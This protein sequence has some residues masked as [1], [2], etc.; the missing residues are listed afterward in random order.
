MRARYQAYTL[1]DNA[2]GTAYPAPTEHVLDLS[3]LNGGLNLWELEYMLPLNQS[4]DLL[5]M[6]WKDGSISSRPGQDYV[7]RA[8]TE[9]DALAHNAEETAKAGASA[10]AGDDPVYVPQYVTADTYG[11]F[12]AGYERLWHD[13]WICQK[14]KK[15][16]AV[17]PEDGTHTSIYSGNLSEEYGGSF[18]V[19]RENLY[20]MNG[21]EYIKISMSGSTMTAADVTPYIPTVVLNRNPDGTG[22]DLYEDE[23]RISAGRKV[24]FTAD[25]ES[26]DYVLPYKNLDNTTMTAVVNGVEVAENSGF[27]VDRTNGIVTFSTAPTQ[28]QLP[29][30]NNVTITCYVTDTDA[31]NSIMNS[32]CAT[33]FG[34]G[35]AVVVVV[36]GTPKQPNAYFWSGNTAYGLDPSYFPYQS[37]NFAGVNNE[38][39][40][41]FGKQQSMLV[42]FKEHSIGKTYFNTDSLDDLTSIT[43]PYTP[44]NDV[45]GCS[46]EKSIKLIQNNLIFANKESG[47]YVLLDTSTAGENNVKRIS[48]NVEGSQDRHGLLYDMR[49]S[50]DYEVCAYDDGERYW[51]CA[52]GRVYLWD[53]EVSTFYTKE[54]KLSWF[55]FDGIA[56]INWLKTDEDDY[57]G[58]ADGSLIK[59]VPVFSDFGQG[60][61]RRYTFA[62]Q[63]FGTY[64]TLKD[65]L[66]V[67]FSAKSNTGCLINIKY[68][69]DYESRDDLTLIDLRLSKSLIPRD[70]TQGRF[71]RA[72][73]Y[74]GTAI[75]IPRC[76]HIRHFS[77]T[78]YN[79]VAETDMGVIGAQVV[80]R[81]SRRD[82]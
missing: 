1:K 5:N 6:Y 54:E 81:Y 50:H 18:F 12:Y 71:L 43:L 46:F 65:V 48:R 57:Y 75:R 51:L 29:V 56:P 42:I 19:L 82:R 32:K 40:T 63:H 23:N 79:D 72:I 22:G 73:R 7:Y 14:G 20:Y 80:Y 60:Y 34:T 38:Y 33:A 64:D 52:N 53:Y 59:F 17:N 77:M 58:R 36:G 25:G 74:A 39:I 76:F 26:V 66:R 28:S 16:Y 47:V 44:I 62:V 11:A 8:W 70:I 35:N 9:E 2:Y 41:G 61:M 30:V 67:I 24:S 31:V 21:H 37:Y 55:L 27:T 10:A 45:I 15:L 49:N 3:T 68:Q 69:T 78:L 13:K 4:P